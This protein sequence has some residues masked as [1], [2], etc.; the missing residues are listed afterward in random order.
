MNTMYRRFMSW[1]LSFAML[2]GAI[3][4]PGMAAAYQEQRNYQAIL[5]AD[6][7]I[8]ENER[9]R[10]NDAELTINENRENVSDGFAREDSTVAGDIWFDENY[11]TDRFIVK[12]RNSTVAET[13]EQAL[14]RVDL[15]EQVELISDTRS[16]DMSNRVASNVAVLTTGQLVSKDVLEQKLGDSLLREIEYMQPDYEMSFYEYEEN[17]AEEELSDELQKSV[18]MN[19]DEEQDLP[20]E[21]QEPVGG[22]EGEEELSEEAQEPVGE[23]EDDEDLSEETQR[24]IEE[25]GHEYT[26]SVL[27]DGLYGD[28]IV[29]L[30][31]T[32]VDTEHDALIGILMDGYDFVN[33]DASVNDAEWYYDQGH[34]TS[35]A[36]IIATSGAVVMPLKVFEGGKAYTSD[37]IAAIAYAEENGARIANLSFGSRFYNPA[38]EEAIAESNMLFVC[39]SGNMLMN[40]DS[41]PVYPAS[42]DLPNV[43]ATGSVGVG[44]TLSRFSNYGV[45]SVDITALGEN[46]SAP[47]LENTVVEVNGTSASAAIISAA[48]AQTLAM[49]NELDATALKQRVVQSADQITGLTDKIAGGKRLN[50]EYALSELTDPNPTVIDVP[51]PDP[52]PEVIPGGDIEEEYEEFGADGLITY[53]LPMPTARY[54]LGVVAIGQKIYAIGGMLSNGNSSDKV[55]IYDI[56]SDTWITGANMTYPVGYFSYVAVGTNIYC[57]GGQYKSGNSTAY[58]NYVQVYNTSNNTWSTKTPGGAS[59]PTLMGTAA[60]EYNGSIY[61]SGGYNGSYRNYVYQ[62]NVSANTWTQRGNLNNARAYHNAFIFDGRMYIEGG[63]VDSGLGGYYIQTEEIYN[64]STHVASLNGASRVFAMN[65]AVI[66]KDDRLIIVGG[67]GYQNGGYLNKIT[68]L[69]I[70]DGNLCYQ[71]HNIMSAARASLGAVMVDGVIYMLGGKNDA[72]IFDWV[73]AMEAGYTALTT[74]PQ[75]LTGFSAVELAGNIYISGGRVMPGNIASRAMYA[76]NILDKTWE[77]KTNLPSGTISNLITSVYGK[78]YL[79]DKN[80]SQANRVFAY[81][82]QIDAWTDIASSPKSFPYVQALNGKIYGFS[83]GSTTVDVFDPLTNTWGQGCARPNSTDFYDTEVL[84]GKMYLYGSDGYIYCYD[85]DIDSWTSDNVGYFGYFIAPVYQ[86]MYLF[87]DYFY[88]GINMI[89]RYSPTNGNVT[90]YRSYQHEYEYIYEICTVNNKVYMFVGNDSVEAIVEY[91]PSVSPWALKGFPTLYNAYMANGATGSSV[92]LAGGYGTLNVSQPFAYMNTLFEYNAQTDSWT[93]K[94]N[95]PTARSKVAGVTAGG[96]FYAIGGETNSAGNSTNKM[97]EYN[98]SNNQWTTKAVLPYTAHSVAVA[99]YGGKIYT[100]GGRNGTSG[101]Y[102]YVREYNP[103]TNQWVTKTNMPTARYG[104]SA[105]ELN[106]KIYVAGGFS[107]SGV[108]L[109]TLEVY[110]P[111]ANSWSTKTAMPAAK[112]YCGGVADDGIYIIGGTDGYTSVNTVYQYNPIVD[113]WY[114]WPGLDDAIEGVAAAALNNGI[115]IINGAYYS[116]TSNGGF[117]ST[118]SAANYY[119][120]TSSISSYAELT[121]LGSDMINPSGNLSRSYNDLSFTA[122][123]FTVDVGRVYNSIDTRDSLVS[124][125]WTFSFSSKLEVVGNDT[126]IRMPN[127]SARSFLTEANGAYA[128]KDSRAEL[129]KSGANHILTTPDHYQYYYNA[130]GYMYRMSDPNGNQVNITVNSSGQVTA[131]TDSV[132]RVIT[133]AYASNRISTITDPAGR[134]TTYGYDANGRLSQVT[135]QNGSKTYYTYDSSGMLYQ[136]KNHNSVVLEQF[137]YET[138]QGSEQQRVKTAKL[139]TGITETYTYDVNEGTVTVTTGSGTNARTAITYFDKAFYPIQTID[140]EGAVSRLEYILDGGINRY[141]E[142]AVR[143][144][145]NGN[146]TFYE[147][148]ARGNVVK[149]IY[150]DGSTRLYTYDAYNN[151]TSETDELGNKTF[152]VYDAKHNLTV[153]AKPLDGA[154]QYTSSANQSLFAIERFVY[155]TTAQAN[156]MC[157]KQIGGLLKTV[158]DPEGGVTTY[159]YDQYGYIATVK[160]PGNNTT[161]YQYNKLGWL[162]S[163]TTPK[164][165]TTT[166]YYDKAGNLLKQVNPDG[167][168]TRN[169]YDSMY[170]LMQQVAPTRYLASA[171]TTAAFSVENIQSSATAPYSQSG[172]GWRYTYNNAGQ[173]LTATDPLSFVTTYTYDTYGNK[174]TETTPSGAKYTYT[175][176]VLNRLL[177]TTIKETSSSATVTLSNS[178]YAILTN[179]HTTVTVTQYLK[180][181]V[182]AVTK[183]TFDYAGRSIRV[184]NAD[185]TYTTSSYNTNGTLASSTDAKGYTTY[186]AYDALNRQTGKWSPVSSGVYSYSG[187]QYDK[188]G[189]VTVRMQSKNTVANGTVPTASLITTSYTYN[190]NGLIT[191]E[192]TSGGAKRTYAYDANGN[193]TDVFTYTGASTSARVYHTY[194]SMDRVATKNTVVQN[195]DITGYDNTSTALVLTASYTYDLNGNMLTETDENN[196]T[197]THTYNLMNRPLKVSRPGTTETGATATISVSKTYDW[198]GNILTSTDEL[199]R[200]TAY[201]YS[202]RGFLTKITD[203]KGG[204]RYFEYDTAGRKTAEVSPNNYVS[205]AALSAMTRTEFTYDLMGRILRET[206]VYQD[207]TNTWKTVVTGAYTYD[208]NGNVVLKKDAVG[209]AGNYGTAFAYDDSNRLIRTTDPENNVSQITYDGAGRI[210]TATDARNVVTSYTYDDNGNVLTIRVGSTLTQTNTYNLAGQRLTTTDGNNNTMVYTYNNLGLVR[211]MTLPSDGTIGA[212]TVNYRY[213]RLGQTAS[214]TDSLGKQVVL[215]YDNHGRVLS[216]TEQEDVG[217][218]VITVSSRY[219]KAG[220]LRYNTDGNGSTTSYSYDVLNRMTSKSVTV[221]GITGTARVHT[222]TCTY[223]ANGNL[224]SETDWRGNTYNYAYDKLN[225]LVK[226]TDPTGAIIETLV[227]NDNN[228]QIYSIDALNNTTEFIYDDAGRL[229]ETIDALNNSFA[230]FY[231]GNGNVVQTLDGNGNSTYYT[232]DSFNRLIEVENAL[233][234][235]TVYTYDTNGNMLTQTDGAGNVATVQYNVRNLP[236]NRIDPGGINGQTIDPAK[237]VSYAYRPDGSVAAMTDKNGV[238]TTYA[239]DI[240]GRMLSQTAGGETLSYTYDNNGNV[241][242]SI[243]DTGTTTRTYDAIGRTISKNVPGIG[244]STY[245]YDVTSNVPANFYGETTTDPKGNAT[246]KIYDRAGRLYQVKNGSDTTTYAY[247]PNGNRQSVTYPNG[248][249]TQYT[250]YADNRLHTMANKKGSS[251]LSTFNYAYDGNGN[252]V[253]KLEQAGTTSYEYDVLN[254]LVTVTEP[255][256]KTTDYSYDAAGNRE[257]QTIGDGSTVTT[258]TYTYNAQNWLLE[259]V[260]L[261]DDYE[262]TTTYGYDDNGNTVEKYVETQ[263]SENSPPPMFPLGTDDGVTYELSEYDAFNRLVYVEN[264]SYTAE[265]AYNAEGLR[266]SK[267]VTILNIVLTTLFL[268]EGGSV[269]LELDEY[270]DQTAFNVY[271]GGSIISRKTNATLYY[272]YNG[273]GDVVQLSNTSGTVTQRYDYDAFGNHETTSDTNPYRYCGEYFDVETSTYYLRARYYRP[274]T[275]RF[276]QQDTYLGSHADPLSLNLYTYCHNN[277]IRYVDPSGHSPWWGGIFT[278]EEYDRLFAG[279][280]EGYVNGNSSSSNSGGGGNPWDGYITPEEYEQVFG[281]STSKNNS[282]TVNLENSKLDISV[283]SSPGANMLGAFVVGLISIVGIALKSTAD[284][285][286]DS[287]SAAPRL[288][289][290]GP[291]EPMSGITLAGTR[292]VTG[293]SVA[294]RSS[295][296]TTTNVLKRVNKGTELYFEGHTKD[297]DGYTWGLVTWFDHNTG[298]YEGG[299]IAM[300]YLPYIT[301]STGSNNTAPAPNAPST[302]PASSG[303]DLPKIGSYASYNDLTDAERNALNDA[304]YRDRPAELWPLGDS[305]TVN[306]NNW[307]NYIDSGLSHGGIDIA[308]REGTEIYSVYYGMAYTQTQT[309]IGGG[310]FVYV[311]ST[312]NGET[313]TIS[314]MHMSS[315]AIESGT[316]V[317]PGQLIGYVGD[318]GLIESGAYHLHFQKNFNGRPG[319]DPRSYLPQEPQR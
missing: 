170:N 103:G 16:S 174:I 52:L 253:T 184:D 210:L 73:E 158:T 90:H 4:P 195:M 160:N 85:P 167:G 146:N 101:A 304:I 180:S 18:G 156:T 296:G 151:V 135:D 166:Y 23:K 56:A 244:M 37:I 42:F 5:D 75:N 116:R 213:T 256:D 24:P 122:P 142:V 316:L 288:A 83:S 190:A 129:V 70:F 3:L 67:S 35:L 221:T 173:V 43:L 268:Y 313:V 157:G 319:D 150:H 171:D 183:T 290:G 10:N 153:Q 269:V 28:L 115:Y 224:L 168:V 181:S 163:I 127:G 266:I 38:L 47:W 219:D 113:K 297:K 139:L 11:E 250:Y 246:T 64:L 237:T 131:V 86:D 6:L 205:T 81:D 126:V 164:S 21:I 227:Y 96:K 13:V 311:V 71:R 1:I 169:V 276:T 216:A 275:G 132:G 191:Q 165:Y 204:V 36:G 291:V 84:A 154:T 27:N 99:S 41:Y 179:G 228:A 148:D 251:Y 312:I 196:I 223:D 133:I 240:H 226:K 187:T 310:N 107:S 192:L 309:G 176:D 9:A 229:T 188:A 308:A 307:P 106:G 58:R 271:G 89:Y 57:F 34:G 306:Y 211:S 59:F 232:Y 140:T 177:K 198:T 294:I 202:P 248:V 14:S 194:N 97:E 282:A 105:V 159:T 200:V 273:H 7:S 217:T 238:V 287:T 125:G 92:Y 249:V 209:Y 104:A 68:Q 111:V 22:N 247:F 295:P 152:Y 12:Y 110:D 272:L 61:V 230:Q 149:V 147:Y 141:G 45:N 144:D 25:L 267:E 29:A 175:Y 262:R 193:M 303:S 145:R 136:V 189:R 278:P 172:H 2:A 218:Q 119:S 95:M 77:Q 214:Q 138:P 66:W 54:G 252:Q 69:S 65:A 201:E 284:I 220:N 100:F 60:V 239:Y 109:K 128:A 299:W 235:T 260:D 185:G 233:S 264:D 55:E 79:F 234:E 281:G 270:G 280:D 118:Y 274:S 242:T 208:A 161:T 258:T 261:S 206:Q 88:D 44:D 298:V 245:L 15:I 182:T 292:H 108:A 31:D 199:G 231:D 318:T 20:E 314:Y 120:P 197:T 46:V 254:R 263:T 265:Y 26:G 130:N 40:I 53:R 279:K 98:P 87:D 121:H 30:L 236:K 225:R 17:G 114:H 300:N 283:A 78:L 301:P 259:T 178:A 289:E 80:T 112:G 317:A 51:D 215:T 134:V 293:D 137:T 50:L 76:Y 74:M 93:Q 91:M 203:A 8:P 48:S 186:Y 286:T 94:A 124:K 207:E 117:A 315:W 305:W 212:Y 102:N 302:N 277:P 222:L 72:Y 243:D 19:E 63:G 49:Y 39:A 257:T 155:Y 82:P 32:G 123:G 255:D 241:L 285:N 62:Y 162:K 143:T 33:N